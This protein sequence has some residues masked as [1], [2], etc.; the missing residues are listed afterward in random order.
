LGPGTYFFNGPV[1]TWRD[2][3]FLNDETLF[4][5]PAEQDIEAY[6]ADHWVGAT[7]RASGQYHYRGFLPVTCATEKDAAMVSSA[8]EAAECDPYLDGNVQEP[9]DY[10]GNDE[11]GAGDHGDCNGRGVG[12]APVDGVL[13]TQVIVLHDYAAGVGPLLPPG[14][15]MPPTITTYGPGPVDPL[16]VAA[17]CSWGFLWTTDEL[18]WPT[19]N[20]NDDIVTFVSRDVPLHADIDGDGVVDTDR[21][22][23][24]D[25]YAAWGAPGV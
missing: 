18:I 15:V 9:Q 6:A 17:L 3:R 21:I 5:V 19:G 7:V 4:P 22:T 23:D 14:H 16:E 2:A 13:E 20:L 10:N 11:F 24:V 8:H 1:G 25:Y 12:L